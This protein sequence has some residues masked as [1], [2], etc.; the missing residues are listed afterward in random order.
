MSNFYPRQKFDHLPSWASEPKHY[1]SQW[2]RLPTWRPGLPKEGDSTFHIGRANYPVDVM[3]DPL[4]WKPR[5]LSL[6]S[7]W[8]GGIELNFSN[9]DD[10]QEAMKIMRNED[11]EKK[12]KAKALLE[13]FPYLQRQLGDDI[14]NKVLL[15]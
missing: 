15:V 6:R 12:N 7:S 11:I 1:L 8:I 2:D 10:F 14:V 3:L 5:A 9:P 13:R 4:T